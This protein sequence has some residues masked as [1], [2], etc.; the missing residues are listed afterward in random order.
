VSA[1]P[2][3][4]RLVCPGQAV[5]HSVPGEALLKPDQPASDAHF[6]NV[7]SDV[8]AIELA[9]RTYAAFGPSKAAI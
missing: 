9:M 1:N 8:W 6:Y 2:G 4:Q 5:K 7:L 3:T